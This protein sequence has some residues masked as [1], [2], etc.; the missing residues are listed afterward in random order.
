L[1]FE[2]API[3]YVV[4]R[5]GG[6]S[7]DGDRSLLSV[8]ASKLH[9]RTPTFVGNESCIEALENAVDW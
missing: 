9:Q 8:S 2:A 5:A 3:G 4:E 1:L 7:S 6:R